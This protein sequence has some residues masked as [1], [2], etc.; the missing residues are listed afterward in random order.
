VKVRPIE[1]PDLDV[2]AAMR[3]RLWPDAAAADLVAEARAFVAGSADQ[4]L[5]AAFIAEDRAATPLGFVELAVR[6]FSDGC[7]SMPVPHVEG[8]YVEPT[9]RGNGVG[10]R[11]L[12]AA[13]GWARAHGFSELASDTGVHNED[14]LRAHQACGFEEV[15]RL[16]KFRKALS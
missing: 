4:I 1:A 11:L 7:T 16:I 13:E 3:G 6:G 15:D 12:D 2:W 5:A 14:S 8:W 10:R 9:A